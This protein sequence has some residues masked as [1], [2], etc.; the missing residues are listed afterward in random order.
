MAAN[1]EPSISTSQLKQVHRD[2]HSVHAVLKQLFAFQL[3]DNVDVI[4]ACLRVLDDRLAFIHEV[5]V[6]TKNDD[7]CPSIFR[8]VLCSA[9]LFA[10]KP[11]LKWS[12]KNDTNS[13]ETWVFLP[14]KINKNQIF[15][16]SDPVEEDYLNRFLKHRK[17]KLPLSDPP[18]TGFLQ[19]VVN[20]LQVKAELKLKAAIEKKK[21]EKAAS[22]KATSSRLSKHLQEDNED[23][24]PPDQPET[25]VLD[26]DDSGEDKLEQDEEPSDKEPPLSRVDRFKDFKPSHKHPARKSPS[27]KAKG[28][29]CPK[30]EKGKGKE[31][32]SKAPCRFTHADITSR[33][34]TN[35]WSEIAHDIDL[36]FQLAKHPGF[37]IE[38]VV[39]AMHPLTVFNPQSSCLNCVVNGVKCI[40]GPSKSLKCEPCERVHSKCSFLSDISTMMAVHSEI[41]TIAS[42]STLGIHTTLADLVLMS[43]KY[44]AQLAN[45]R[46]MLLPLQAQ[47][48][49]IKVLQSR[50]HN[51]CVD[52]RVVFEYL[53]QNPHFTL[54]A[55]MLS[56]LSFFLSWET[57]PKLTSNTHSVQVTKDNELELVEIESKMVV[58]SLPLPINPLIPSPLPT[59]QKDNTAVFVEVLAVDLCPSK[60]SIYKVANS[61]DADQEVGVSNVLS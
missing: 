49:H 60:S 16:F 28:S 40:I 8:R 41:Q 33:P 12:P 21:A 25:I 29:K 44:E 42:Q 43:N 15:N 4:R 30:V 27:P 1:W 6:E 54:K 2:L 20:E 13:A 22:S 19:E 31:K 18:N 34:C 32:V 3:Q 37:T 23:S 38:E 58:R 57:V 55:T 7:D 59:V 11:Q 53:Q 46:R 50:L 24:A 5:F 26:E 35:K 39:N 36:S 48:H 52:S 51:Q 10:H 61:G 47:E 14:D 9:S 17:S 56:F 45:A